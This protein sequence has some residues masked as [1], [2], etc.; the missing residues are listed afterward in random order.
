MSFKDKD[1]F[2]RLRDRMEFS[3]KI[4]NLPNRSFW[5]RMKSLDL[6]ARAKVYVDRLDNSTDEERQQLLR[7]QAEV[8]KI[9]GVFTEDFMSIVEE[10]RLKR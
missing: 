6:D 1:V 10:L 4:K 2:D 3:V 9:G 7:E 8:M 5:L